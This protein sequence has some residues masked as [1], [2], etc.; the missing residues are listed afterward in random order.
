MFCALGLAQ[1]M[2]CVYFPQPTIPKTRMLLNNP[3]PQT[4]LIK[5]KC[6]C[7]ST[8]LKANSKISSNTFPTSKST[9]WTSKTLTSWN[10]TL[11]KAPAQLQE[12]IVTTVEANTTLTTHLTCTTNTSVHLSIQ[13]CE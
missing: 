10:K 8:L 11:S 13:T 12:P 4:N 9:T 3:P 5:T 1:A 2:L 6:A 7:V